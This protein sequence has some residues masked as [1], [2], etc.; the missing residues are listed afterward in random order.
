MVY[1]IKSSQYVF[2]NN[3]LIFSLQLT[4]PTVIS[5]FKNNNEYEQLPVF[6]IKSI[7]SK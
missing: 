3:L 4:T 1:N 2:P 7:I 6:Y 5:L